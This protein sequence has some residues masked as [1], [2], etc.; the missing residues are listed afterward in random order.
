MNSPSP[1][2]VDLMIAKDRGFAQRV[3]RNDTQC[4]KDK[5]CEK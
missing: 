5:G 4:Q 2:M 3:L 1:E